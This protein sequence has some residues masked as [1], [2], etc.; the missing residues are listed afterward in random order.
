M[1]LPRRTRGAIAVP[2]MIALLCAGVPAQ[3]GNTIT[4][5]MLEGRTGR[6]VMTTDFLVQINHQQEQ[7]ANWVTLNEDG[8]GKLTLPPGATDI[9]IHG[10]YDSSMSVYV[11]CDMEK[12][13]GILENQGLLESAV[14]PDRWYPVTDI[15]NSGVVAPNGCLSKKDAA[16]QKIA[17]K[18]GEFVFFVRKKN[19]REEDTD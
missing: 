18:P 4:V 17:P 1:V 14:A 15:L 3:T 11:N 6:L 10:K 5:R 2:F 9:S 12:G 8:S 16:K 13:K 7:H 19:W